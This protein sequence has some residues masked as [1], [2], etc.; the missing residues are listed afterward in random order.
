MQACIFRRSPIAISE[1]LLFPS[2]F[3]ERLEVL[4]LAPAEAR[5]E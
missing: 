1:R 3:P 5:R 4:N 2:L